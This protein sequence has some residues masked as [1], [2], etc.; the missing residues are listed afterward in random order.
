M[1]HPLGLPLTLR[2]PTPSPSSKVAMAVSIQ[3]S[4]PTTVLP[5]RDGQGFHP[6]LGEGLFYLYPTGIFCVFSE[7]GAE[8]MEACLL[9][10][11]IQS[12]QHC[13]SRKHILMRNS[14]WPLLTSQDSLGCDWWTTSCPEDTWW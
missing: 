11:G 3:G 7:E 10:A 14:D 4:S 1:A 12:T 6:I 2:D 13:H 9:L 5:V 8:A